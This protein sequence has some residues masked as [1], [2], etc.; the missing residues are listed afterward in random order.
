[1][2]VLEVPPSDE[3]KILQTGLPPAC[4][5]RELLLDGQTPTRVI[6]S[7]SKGELPLSGSPA[8]R[9]G[10][11]SGDPL[12]GYGRFLRS[13]FRAEGGRTRQTPSAMGSPS[14]HDG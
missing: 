11:Q 12:M 10:P 6:S 2:A 8:P 3:A 14:W 13:Y 7:Q 5:R 9:P 4:P 1:M